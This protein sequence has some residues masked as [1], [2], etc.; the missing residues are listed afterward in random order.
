MCVNHGR[1]CH[2]RVRKQCG[3]SRCFQKEVFG[4]I[5]SVHIRHAISLVGAML[6]FQL[7]CTFSARYF[8]YF[9]PA[10]EILELANPFLGTNIYSDIHYRTKR[11]RQ[12][13]DS[14]VYP[15]IK[16]WGSGLIQRSQLSRRWMSCRTYMGS[17]E[18]WPAHQPAFIIALTQFE[19]QPY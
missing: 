9:R 10:W 7:C 12:S 11:S 2:S 5:V 13:I 17:M 6:S 3:S 16:D 1:K 4:T 18:H 8:R 15:T 14:P 19:Q